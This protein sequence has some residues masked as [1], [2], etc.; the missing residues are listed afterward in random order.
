MVFFTRLNVLTECKHARASDTRNK[1]PDPAW[2]VIRET[3]LFK[4]AQSDTGH[5]RNTREIDIKPV[6]ISGE[7][8][9]A[10]VFA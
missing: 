4:D 6:L 1:F 10:L 9:L 5:R 8:F 7:S 3:E 2:T